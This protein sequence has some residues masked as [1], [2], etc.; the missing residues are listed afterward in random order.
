MEYFSNT[1]TT[2]FSNYRKISSFSD[3]MN[4]SYLGPSYDDET[5]KIELNNIGAKYEFKDEENLNHG[6]STNCGHTSDRE[7]KNINIINNH[8]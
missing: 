8:W 5:I 7:K 6:I 2:K 4:G 1:M 3:G